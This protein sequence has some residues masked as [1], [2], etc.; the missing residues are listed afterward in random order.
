MDVIGDK[1]EANPADCDHGELKPRRHIVL[2]TQ[3][4]KGS[5]KMVTAT[6]KGSQSSRKLVR[7][8]K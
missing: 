5:Y 2:P 1:G 6:F 8:M 7:N 4:I 3:F